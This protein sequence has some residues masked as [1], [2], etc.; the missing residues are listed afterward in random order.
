[1]KNWIFR[2]ESP[3]LNVDT[4][5][6]FFSLPLKKIILNH[7]LFPFISLSVHSPLLNPISSTQ[8]AFQ[9]KLEG[10]NFCPDFDSLMLNAHISILEA[11]NHIDKKHK[12]S[13]IIVHDP[14]VCCNLDNHEFFWSKCHFEGYKWENIE[15]R[16]EEVKQDLNIAEM[17]GWEKEGLEN[18][19]LG[20][21]KYWS[22]IEYVLI[23]W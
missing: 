22:I 4:L 17:R 10:R 18:R 7:F 15:C 20:S 1:M 13:G 11:H 3:L 6:P 16:S 14:R 5:F 9:H 2:L 8:V 12:L 23:K 19:I 21:W